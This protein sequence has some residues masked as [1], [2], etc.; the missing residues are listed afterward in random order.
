MHS[1]KAFVAALIT[2]NAFRSNENVFKQTQTYLNW[3]NFGEY[4]NI[5]ERH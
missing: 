2:G 1:Q 5:K 4:V 3:T